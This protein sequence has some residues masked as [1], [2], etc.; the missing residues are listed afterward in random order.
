MH[1]LNLLC[2]LLCA[3]LYCELCALLYCVL[4]AARCGGAMSILC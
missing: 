4:Y 2:A 1:N 3:L